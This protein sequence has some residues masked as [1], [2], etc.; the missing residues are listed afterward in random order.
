M[1]RMHRPQLNVPSVSMGLS[2]STSAAN[3]R[4]ETEAED[5]GDVDMDTS[6]DSDTPSPLTMLIRMFFLLNCLVISRSSAEHLW[7]NCL[8]N[9]R[10]Y[11]VAP[12]DMSTL[13]HAGAKRDLQRGLQT[14]GV[15][16]HG[17]RRPTCIARNGHQMAIG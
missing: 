4:P 6:H 17:G 11:T 13:G 5:D 14:T 7:L 15:I 16:G 10:Q 8:G 12:F 1:R 2:T 3:S 9:G